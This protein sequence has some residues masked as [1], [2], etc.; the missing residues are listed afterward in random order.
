MKQTLD[1]LILVPL[2]N[3]WT[4]QVEITLLADSRLVF[5]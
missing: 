5:V 3:H 2:H 1:I 4:L